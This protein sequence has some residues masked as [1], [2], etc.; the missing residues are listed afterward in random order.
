MEQRAV[1][2]LTGKCKF[3]HRS[4]EKGKAGQVHL[5]IMV[6]ANGPKLVKVVDT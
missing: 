3:R 2:N 5:Y 1:F 4:G 6:G